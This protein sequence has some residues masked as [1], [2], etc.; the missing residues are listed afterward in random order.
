MGDGLREMK[1]CLIRQP[2]GIGDILV[3]K[4]IGHI[5]KS[6]GYDI[7]WPIQR[8]IVEVLP[9]IT[10][11]FNYI[12]EDEFFPFF[13]IYHRPRNNQ[14]PIRSEELLYLPIQYATDYCNDLILRSKFV[15]AGIESSDWSH[16]LTFNRN[17]KKEDELYYNI[18]GLKD[19][20]EYVLL[21]LNYGTQPGSV[22]KSIP[23]KTNKKIIK[24]SFIPGITI[25]DWC[26]VIESASELHMIDTC[27]TVII[28][29]LNLQA[30]NVFLYNR[31]GPLENPSYNE[32]IYLYSKPWK[33]CY[34]P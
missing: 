14:S 16:Y 34:L 19:K 9:Y 13:E 15:L 22:E 29:K 5:Y 3:C 26:K 6:L 8:A 10:T 12:C 25:F 31:E 20:E 33:L 27:F 7:I 4:K 24:T 18:L 11:D 28:E 23:L 17:Q 30:N 2:A 32:S 21:N 1:T